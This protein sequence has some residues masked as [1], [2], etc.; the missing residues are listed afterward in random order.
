MIQRNLP[1]VKSEA[2]ESVGDD[3]LVT[4]G[5]SSKSLVV[6]GKSN[7]FTGLE[8]S[9]WKPPG[10]PCNCR[11]FMIFSKIYLKQS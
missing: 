2:F 11:L 8:S 7:R 4:V 3:D 1:E 5:E 6:S 9:G 10:Q